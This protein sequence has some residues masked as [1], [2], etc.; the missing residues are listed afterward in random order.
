MLLMS[1]KLSTVGKPCSLNTV[2]TI[3]QM[4]LC[5]WAGRLGLARPPNANPPPPPPSPHWGC[6]SNGLDDSDMH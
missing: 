6:L 5:G 1:N 4:W 3:F 2:T